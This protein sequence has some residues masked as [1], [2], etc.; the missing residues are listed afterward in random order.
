MNEKNQGG[1]R[2]PMTHEVKCW[3]EVFPAVK[4]GAK[5]WEL[6]LNDRGYRVGDTLRQFEWDNEA[7]QYTGDQVEHRIGF[8]LY[9]PAF[10]LPDGYVIMTLSPREQPEPVAEPDE[11]EPWPESPL[12]NAIYQHVQSQFC[13]DRDEASDEAGAILKILSDHG[14]YAQPSKQ[15]GGG[16]ESRANIALRIEQLRQACL[17]NARN[18]SPTNFDVYPASA[19]IAIEHA[20]NNILY[21]L[22]PSEQAAGG[23]ERIALEEIKQISTDVRRQAIIQESARENEDMI[24][25]LREALNDITC[26]ASAALSTNGV[27]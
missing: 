2:M 8:A 24:G 11:D 6:R 25:H 22:S 23:G 7:C 13:L 26:I 27:A 5:P 21:V 12:A 18:L 10:G 9:G 14:V 16:G 4:S 19:F 1:E 17:H 3:K 20:L 15:T